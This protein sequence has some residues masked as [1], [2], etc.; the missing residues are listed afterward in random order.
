MELVSFFLDNLT[1]SH[2]KK[3]C[4]ILWKI[5]SSR[6][7]EEDSKLKSL[8]GLTCFRLSSELKIEGKSIANPYIKEK[9]MELSGCQPQR[10][11][12]FVDE[13]GTGVSYWK[14]VGIC[15]LSETV[16]TCIT[17]GEGEKELLVYSYTGDGCKLLEENQHFQIEVTEK[18]VEPPQEGSY[19]DVVCS[20][21]SY[22]PII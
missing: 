2:F 21:L 7:C 16:S 20:W 15:R 6:I 18:K 3:F 1:I 10:A 5:F 4:S 13:Q 17:M 8:V 19:L 14:D 9:I 12:Q 11:V 22:I